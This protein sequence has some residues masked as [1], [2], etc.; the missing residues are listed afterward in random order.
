MKKA[1]AFGTVTAVVALLAGYTLGAAGDHH[2]VMNKPINLKDAKFAPFDPNNPEGAQVSFVWGNPKEGPS[3]FF[4]KIPA[5][6]NAGTHKHTHNYHGVVLTGNGS[7]HWDGDNEKGK[8]VYKN[9]TYWRQ[10]GGEWHGDSCDSKQD[11]IIFLAFD[12]P[13]DFI[14]K[15]MPADSGKKDTKKKKK[16]S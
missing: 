6:M 5:G 3:A 10:T 7:A 15:D 11:C 14:P 12:G 13:V 4:L 2:E 1:L 16:K 8:H 9:H